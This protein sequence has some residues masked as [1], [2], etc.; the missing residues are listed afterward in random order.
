MARPLIRRKYLSLLIIIVSLFLILIYGKA[1]YNIIIF[2]HPLQHVQQI[3]REI[4]MRARLSTQNQELF[5]FLKQLIN[6][7][8][9]RSQT[10][11]NY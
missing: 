3:V 11:Q 5:H 2:T 1:I 4:E 10:N 8:G 9:C 6:A 7:N